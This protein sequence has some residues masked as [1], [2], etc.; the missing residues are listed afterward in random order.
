MK[1]QHAPQFGAIA[2]S[3]LSAGCASGQN[4]LPQA[5]TGQNISR[6]SLPLHGGACA[7]I[8]SSANFNGTAIAP[9][10]WIW[11]SSVVS[12]PGYKGTLQVEMTKSQITFSD[13]SR[14]YT[15]DGPAMTFALTDGDGAHLTF[16]TSRFRLKAPNGTAGNDFLNGIAYQ[17]TSGLP[18]GIQNVT[19]SAKFY[20]TSKQQIN[21]QWGAAVYTTFT[22]AYGQLGVKALDD[23]H[24]PPYNADDAG[25][26]EAFKQY[27]TGGATGGGGSNYTGGLSGTTKITPCL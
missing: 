27:V 20:S 18:G 4:A 5:V 17:T 26:P 19:W 15:I 2:L 6:P 22:N 23:N 21:W 7:P 25:T 10:S 11:F 13:G 16:K 24:Y 1:A 3:V 9:G 8:S 14:I 12:V